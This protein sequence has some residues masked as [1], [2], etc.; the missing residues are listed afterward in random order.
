MVLKT[1]MCCILERFSCISLGMKVKKIHKVLKFKQ[2]D[3][4]KSFVMFN[5]KKRINAAN[6]F[7]KDFFK[8]MIDVRKRVRKKSKC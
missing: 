3:W 1:I 8:L 6:K 7:E 5:T 2:S 4:L